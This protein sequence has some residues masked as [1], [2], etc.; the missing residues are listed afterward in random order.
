MSRL[1]VASGVRA[2][3][4]AIGRDGS[5]SCWLSVPDWYHPHANGSGLRSQYENAR[6]LH[7]VRHPL[8]A[9]ESLRVFFHPSW[10]HWQQQH[11]G[12]EY[13]RESYEFY[14]K[15]WVKWNE[16][17]DAQSPFA[18]FRIEFPEEDWPAVA[19]ELGV[20]GMPQVEIDETWKTKKKPSITWDDLGD[21][22]QMVRSMA[23]K[24]GYA[25]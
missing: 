4:E 13:D 16:L 5:V 11:T 18:R 2:L 12:I 10:W 15:F 21:A 14:G 8:R 22:K 19:K 23:D 7:I 1:L 3:H 6:L 24:M 25:E 20:A 9:V 17:I